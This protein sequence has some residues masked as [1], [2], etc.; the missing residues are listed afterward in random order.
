MD[1][2]KRIAQ[3]Q[4]YLLELGPSIEK[5]LIGGLRDPERAIRAS[6][7]DVLGEIGGDASLTALRTLQD[8]DKAV[9]AAA[10][11][12]IERITLRHDRG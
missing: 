4:P 10:R 5:E 8:P 3:V 6:V 9:A 2:D 1:D 12:A 11:R 7:A